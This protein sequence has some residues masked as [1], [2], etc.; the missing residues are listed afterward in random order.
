MI[1][2]WGKWK[3]C[4]EWEKARMKQMKQGWSE[5]GWVVGQICLTLYVDK[6]PDLISLLGYNKMIKSIN[7]K[8]PF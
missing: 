1:I 2:G 3:W 7:L 5:S 4:Q 8:S 6:V